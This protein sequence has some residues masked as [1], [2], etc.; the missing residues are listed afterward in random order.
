LSITTAKVW[1]RPDLGLK[2]L[3]EFGEAVRGSNALTG[4]V[5]VVIELER[6]AASLSLGKHARAL[7][8][9]SRFSSTP[10]ELYLELD[11]EDGSFV[12]IDSPEAVRAAA[13]R[14]RI[15][16][17]VTETGSTSKEIAG[18]VELPDATVRRHLNALL[19]LGHVTRTGAGKRNDPY[20]WHPGEPS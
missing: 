5:D 14:E 11:E 15:V 13:E 6:P 10:D 17:T 18:E 7:R 4:G 19:G 9:V 2:S 3:G 8:A 12:A 20:R 16:A 1:T